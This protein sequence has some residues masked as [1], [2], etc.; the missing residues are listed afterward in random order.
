M[1]ATL[2]DG[3]LV[4][5]LDLFRKLIADCYWWR[6]LLDENNPWDETT[7][8][9]HTHIDALPQPPNGVYTSTELEA[10]RPFAIVQNAMSDGLE[11]VTR[12]Q[13]GCCSLGAGHVEIGLW[14]SVPEALTNQN[15]QLGAELNKLIGRLIWTGD[16]TKPGMMDLHGTQG[17]PFLKRIQCGSYWRVEEE[18]R[19]DEG[20]Y[21]YAELDCYWGQNG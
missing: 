15:S 14:I 18:D 9:Q 3:P 16:E 19:N 5:S 11:I 4:H 12:A 10:L 8:M 2:P 1:T 20:D 17:Y 6:R 21:V 13:N 7:A